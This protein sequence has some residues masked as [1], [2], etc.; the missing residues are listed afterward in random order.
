MKAKPE[1]DVVPAGICAAI[2]TD[3]DVVAEP[4]HTR[5]RLACAQVFAAP[6]YSG[7]NEFAIAVV[8]GMPDTVVGAFCVHAHTVGQCAEP[9]SLQLPLSTTEAVVVG[10]VCIHARWICTGAGA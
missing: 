3:V 8:T 10:A 5:V 2:D 1:I 4:E 9:A 7:A 6:G